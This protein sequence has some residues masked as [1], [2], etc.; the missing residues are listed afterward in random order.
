[1]EKIVIVGI[2]DNSLEELIQILEEHPHCK[3]V[4]RIYTA[5]QFFREYKPGSADVVIIDATLP[6]M[7]F[8]D[9]ALEVR[10]IDQKALIIGSAYDTGLIDPEE[11]K[12]TVK[13]SEFLFKNNN[14]F[15]NVEQIFKWL[16]NTKSIFKKK[17][18]KKERQKTILAIDDF[19][20]TL[21][22]IEY[23]LKSNGYNVVG[24]L[25]AKE[26][27]QK[28]E[29]GLEPD[30]IITD[31][32]MPEIDGFKFIEEVRN[33]QRY[34]KIP[35]FILTTDFGFEK[36]MKA[37][38]LNINVWIQKPYKIEEFLKIIKQTIG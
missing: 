32:N 9:F 4:Y 29:E 22:V 6:D 30:L 37:K 11:F 24:A 20:N 34:S 17:E 12:R 21:N 1:M 10:K 28:L 2:P 14:S 27:L 15:N 7:N 18:E 8:T 35:I 3:S 26:A 23:T 31:L 38:K 19:E 36:K 13:N 16:D 33:M 25:S 5:N